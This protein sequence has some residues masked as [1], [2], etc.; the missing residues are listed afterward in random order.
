MEKLVVVERL[1]IIR[2]KVWIVHWELVYKEVS[3]VDKWAIAYRVWWKNNS[4]KKVYSAKITCFFKRGN[5]AFKVIPQYCTA[6][7]LCA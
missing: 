4:E 3:T 1:N 2:V 7:S 5:F 6:H